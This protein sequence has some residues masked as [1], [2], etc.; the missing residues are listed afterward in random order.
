[1]EKAV[2]W[3]R[4]AQNDGSNEADWKLVECYLSEKDVEQSYDMAAGNL[5]SAHHWSSGHDARS[6]TFAK[7]LDGKTE[8][9]QLHI[10]EILADCYSNGIG[11]EKDEEKAKK[12]QSKAEILK[13]ELEAESQAWAEKILKNKKKGEW[14]WEEKK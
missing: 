9:H 5:Y 2:G 12:H 11:T 6:F 3:Y 7:M 4:R 10:C 14:L 8:T 13:S 1:M